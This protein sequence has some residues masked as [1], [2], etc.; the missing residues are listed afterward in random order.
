MTSIMPLELQPNL[1]VTLRRS[2]LEVLIQA[3]D[4][5]EILFCEPQEDCHGFLIRTKN[6]GW[7]FVR[8]THSIA[9]AGYELADASISPI[10]ITNLPHASGRNRPYGHQLVKRL[11]DAIRSVLPGREKAIVKY[12]GEGTYVFLAGRMT[13]TTSFEINALFFPKD[14]IGRLCANIPVEPGYG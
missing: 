1:S 3:V 5:V 13:R 11:R 6:T 8:L 12:Y 9:F 4:D 7:R 14:M 10:R 2:R